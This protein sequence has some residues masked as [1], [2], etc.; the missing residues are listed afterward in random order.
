MTRTFRI[1]AAV[2]ILAAAL[3]QAPLF[4]HHS[5]AM[6][7]QN[8]TVTVTGV[9][10]Q[11][12]PQANHAEFHLVLLTDDRK[13]LEKGKDGKYVEFGVEMAGT[14]QLER[15]G[16]TAQT[17]P[18]GTVISVKVNP[19]RDGNNFGARISAI[20]RCPMDP[21]TNKPKLPEAG[22][23]CDSV[24]GRTLNGGETF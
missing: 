21:A 9:V 6:Y 5:F 4:A 7:D 19:L 13:G 14:A 3:L 24:A 15:Q 16:V 17:F 22:K 12:V 20:A 23:H 8:K 11:Y 1:L 2:T 10:K 18:V